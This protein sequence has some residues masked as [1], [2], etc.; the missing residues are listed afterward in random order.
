MMIFDNTK[1]NRQASVLMELFGKVVPA[2]RTKS[3][4]SRLFAS[5]H[6]DLTGANSL[7]DVKLREHANRRVDLWTVAIEHD[8]H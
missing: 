2:D 1:A 5:G 8:D 7:N 4:S 3:K 6:D